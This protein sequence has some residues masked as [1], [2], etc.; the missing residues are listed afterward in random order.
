MR[1]TGEVM[2]IDKDF[3]A[4]F[5]KAS[6]AAG[7]KLPKTG[8]IFLS[9]A[10]K[11]KK[12]I[13]P[14]ARDLGNMGFGLVATTGTA[15][16]LRAAGV[17]VELVFKIQEGRPNPVDL[18]KNGEIVL[19]MMTSS[20]DPADLRDGKDIRRLTLANSIPTITTLAGARATTL[21]LSSMRRQPLELIPLQD[22]FPDYKDMS[23]ALMQG[24]EKVTPF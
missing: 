13:I 2:G 10:D 17:P 8:K 20:G 3:A 9:M 18:I 23:L 4:A 5:A 16:A 6:L 14:I 15:L 12:D 19:A 11:Y 21:A 7:Q 24:L 22:F 1:S